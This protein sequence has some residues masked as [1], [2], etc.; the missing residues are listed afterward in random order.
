[1]LSN[2]THLTTDSLMFMFELIE[3]KTKRESWP[4]DFDNVPTSDSVGRDM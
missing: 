2:F 1:M 3:F 4:S